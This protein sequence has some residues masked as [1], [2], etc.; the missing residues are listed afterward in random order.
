[1]RELLGDLG[2]RPTK[3]EVLEPAARVQGAPSRR[4]GQNPRGGGGYGGLQLLGF[5][6]RDLCV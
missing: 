5:E 4:L 1:M 6:V 2:F 3:E